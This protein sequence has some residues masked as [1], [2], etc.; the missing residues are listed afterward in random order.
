MA[1]AREMLE[2]TLSDTEFGALTVLAVS[3]VPLSGRGVATA[4]GVSPTTANDA[5]SVLGKAGFA[6]S[7]KSGRETLWRVDVENP[8][9]GAWLAELA[10]EHQTT[11]AGS[12]P[13]STG[14]GG[15]RL[16]HSY[17]A[18][19][20]AYFLAGD[21]LQELGDAITVDSIR[22][23][24]SDLSDV[25]DI[26]LEGHSAHGQR[27]RASIAVRRN[28]LLTSSDNVSVPLIR[29]F[30]AIVTEQWVEVNSGRWQ[31]VLAVSTNS[32]AVT[33]VAELAELA[34]ALPTSHDLV[35]R[36]RQ[37]GR[38]N[39]AIRDRYDHLKNLV[40]KAAEKLPSTEVLSTDELLWRLLSSLITRNLRLERTDR[41]DRTA[42]V[43]VLQKVHVNGTPAEADALFSRLEELV[44]EWA[45]QGGVLNQ[46]LI[47]QRLSNFPLERSA[48]F[49]VAW[50]LLDRLRV[51]LRESVRPA[52]QSG[53]QALELERL[54]EKTRLSDVMQ[55]T[56]K[57]AG[58]LVVT[59]D[60]DVGKS[61][62]A[63]RVAEAL[64]KEGAAIVSL[65]LRDLPLTPT[66]L[67]AQLDGHSLDEILGAGAV[68]PVRLILVD[69]A[70][71]V[72]EGKSQIFR[73]LVTAGLRAG[74]GVVCVTRT[75]GSRQVKE[76]LSRALDLAESS[77]KPIEHTVEPLTKDERQDL[78]NAFTVLTRV[79]A[80]TRAS[81]VLGR[82]GLVDALLRSGSNLDPGD[83]LCEADV[84]SAVWRSLI[85]RDEIHPPGAASP[86]DRDYAAQI[87]AKRTLG[88]SVSPLPG[89]AS[90][91]LRSDGVLRVPVNPAITPG[92]EFATDLFRDFA[93]CRLFVTQ[94]W[95]ALSSTG[96]PRWAIRAARLACQAALV[97][98]N[99]R[100]SWA[101]LSDCFSEIASTQGDRWVEVPYEALLTL[102]D[103]ESAIR[104]LWAT[105][106]D[107]GSAGLCVLLRLA[108]S[109]YVRETIGD[110]FALAP[111]VKVAFC[112]RPSIDRRLQFGH[113]VVD[114]VIGDLVLAWLRG[115]AA[116]AMQPDP[117]RQEVRDVILEDDPPLHDAFAIEALACLGADIDDRAAAWLRQ[118][119][120][121][122]P[123]SLN[124]AVESPAVFTSMSKERPELL[125]GLAEAYYIELP[126][127]DDHWY[128]GFPYEGI[129]DFKHGLG[130]AFGTPGAAWYY[131]P[132]FRLLH[133]MP[134]ETISFINRML[135]H[136]ARTR[137]EKTYDAFD[138]QRKAAEPVGVEL[139]IPRIGTRRYIGDNHVWAWY[140]G[141]SVGP[142]PCMSALLALERFIDYMLESLDIPARPI[143][144]VLLRDC[145]NLAVPGLL[146]G[147]LTRHPNHVG[148]LLDAFFEHPEVWHLETSRV[149]AEHFLVRDRD[150]DNLSGND[151]R[152]T[153]P[154]Q[155][156]A[157]MVINAQAN[158]DEKRLA[159]LADIGNRLIEN[160]KARSSG[161]ASDAE[162]IA[163]VE[164]WAAGFHPNNYRASSSSEGVLI[165]Y[166]RPAEIEQVLA[167]GSKELQNVNLM[168][169]LQNR[170][171]LHNGNPENWPHEYLAEDLAVARH[172][173]DTGTVPKSF[174]GPENALVAVAA[175]T[176]RSHAMGLA[177][178]EPAD[179]E[180]AANAIL[181]A[182]NN[183]K[184]DAT[185]ISSS[186]FIMSADRA[187]ATS[188]PLLLLPPF[189]GLE[190]DL[191]Q[192]EACL[193]SL[194]TSLF[195]EVRANYV[196]GT[197]PV[198]AAPC[199]F[200]ADTDSCR[201]H[202]P[203][204]TAALAGLIDCGLG[205]WNLDRSSRDHEQQ[206]PAF[207]ESLHLVSDE[208]LLV[209]RLRMPLACM[210]DARNVPCLHDDVAELWG[211]LWDA[212]C[213]GLAYR[214]R[215]GF[216]RHAHITHEPIA[217]R[218]IEVV[219]DGRHDVVGS[220]IEA[221]ATGSNALHLLFDGF[222][223]VFTYDEGLRANLVDFWPWALK[224][225]LD[226]IGDET[227][228]L[229]RQPW[230]DY[231]VA[232]LLP[233]PSPRSVDLDIDRTL[234]ECRVNWIQPAALGE[235]PDQWLRIAS[236]QAKA[237]DA[238]VKFAKG[239]SREW[240]T[241]VALEWIETIIDGRF[242][243][244][245]NRL[246]I[247]EEWLADLRS[248]G[249]IVGPMRSRYHRIVDGLAA[250]GDH[251]AV[252]LQ[253]L[254][255]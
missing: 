134:G 171:G 62:L 120:D 237:V 203:A 246:W 241:T 18:Y 79:G 165:E 53:R 9:I 86:D 51:R 177:D 240:Q 154:H 212:H 227:E 8:S 103:A 107:N 99:R 187:A 81:S 143:L 41:A 173:I 117:V 190:L 197:L 124:A 60:P 46:S 82:P 204:W 192:V 210:I 135:D 193:R 202:A 153:T 115:M 225:A 252:R 106:N 211:P 209:N 119:A 96:A 206:L 157:E 168:Y 29:D 245:A 97:G 185:D 163:I 61:A 131:G 216:D 205:S 224:I 43:N 72:L 11:S 164:G 218:M 122:H 219:L 118:V 148:D 214:W 181:W 220:H 145:N 176:V 222:A 242:D 48:S 146:V 80:D 189:D 191:Q 195:D 30:L 226:A 3:T 116:A 7:R 98:T 68:R 28:P 108:E 95:G 159:H 100:A 102:G 172:L 16:E 85:R 141:S 188:V 137:V 17:A 175:A 49:A 231:L 27:H 170:Y 59:G 155:T 77:Y 25:D 111:L 142:Y 228:H 110:A 167:P 24:A 56:G 1:T 234:A 109:R 151:R 101:K 244:F 169:R 104:D 75:D 223:T 33:Q 70:E 93:L 5:L 208:D 139:D 166:E 161:S 90:A 6:T 50:D 132:F 183:P 13:Y 158:G 57:S 84:F 15:V 113:R 14:G 253:Q 58:A 236:G 34:R 64:E 20:I 130:D 232:A 55:S 4:L 66:E 127:P 47:R 52:L 65:S 217:R 69:G 23:Q 94:G 129:R 136:A 121:E 112:D 150:A 243:L 230:F 207:H 19:L 38:T 182:G 156:V 2:T 160:A 229:S 73:E 87:V 198:W 10:P 37:S 250:A 149:V 162:Y 238:V 67:E 125:L 78:L 88:I 138:N 63:L 32:N 201:R 12:S 200:D 180:W 140:R 126:D 40:K 215:E 255:E 178:L 128:G 179:V 249:A 36:L 92:D 26:L 91:E 196:K 71:S 147:F 186:A 248:S 233:T 74:F 22:L 144:Y 199:D 54:D 133:S 105:L 235:L 45:P 76:E 239:A 44:G 247:L 254:E 39:T 213:R 221:L 89:T 83:L 114:E 21:S 123:E 251:G 194:G 152:S 42:A 184:I 35:T 31:L 174:Y